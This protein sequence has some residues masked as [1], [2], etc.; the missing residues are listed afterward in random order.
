MEHLTAMRCWIAA[1]GIGLQATTHAGFNSTAFDH[2][3]TIAIEVSKIAGGMMLA[4]DWSGHGV[5]LI[6]R[7]ARAIELLRHN[8]K[9]LGDPNDMNMLISLRQAAQAD[10]NAF[11]SLI[12]PFNEQQSTNPLRSVKPDLVVLS[13]TSPYSGCIVSYRARGDNS[14]PAGWAGGFIDTCRNVVFDLSGRVLKGHQ[15]TANLNLLA[16]P[17]YYNNQGKLVLGVRGQ[18]PRRIDFRP[19][20]DYRSMS[21][22]ERLTTAAYY[23]EYQEVQAAIRAGADINALDQQGSTALMK[24]IVENDTRIVRWL[25]EHGADANARNRDLMRPICLAA[26]TRNAEII[27]LLGQFGANWAAFSP[28]RPYC[29]RPVLVMAITEA[30]SENRAVELVH[31]LLE[32][33]ATPDVKYQGKSLIEFA[34]EIG[35]PKVERALLRA[36][37]LSPGKSH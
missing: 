11:A 2:P 10:G 3:E 13:M 21:P 22:V 24:A 7:D 5:M 6:N 33:G 17:H 25:L 4:V 9:E 20:L 28:E 29:D 12:K 30:G 34:R 23:G 14:L 19:K 37:T 31:V 18:A 8:Q 36:Q 32:A 16:I 1:L 27:R 15:Q 26:F 35:Y